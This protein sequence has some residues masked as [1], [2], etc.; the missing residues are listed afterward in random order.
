MITAASAPAAR[1]LITLTTLEESG[2]RFAAFAGEL[3][4]SKHRGWCSNEDRGT[5]FRP[6]IVR[7]SSGRSGARFVAGY[8]VSDSEVIVLDLGLT[9]QGPQAGELGVCEAAGEAAA[10]A[11]AISERE[12]YRFRT[13]AASRR[14]LPQALHELGLR[15]AA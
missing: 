14:K 11:D 15:W 7:T 12:A 6:L 10:Y 2:F 4:R 3:L 9:F 8:Q 1:T 5:V 13:L